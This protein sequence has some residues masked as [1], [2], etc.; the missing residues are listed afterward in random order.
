MPEPWPSV[1]T[2]THLEMLSPGELKPK[3]APAKQATIY[4]VPQPMPSLNRFFYYA[5][6]EEWGWFERRIWSPNDWSR[7]LNRPELETWIVSWSGVPAGY[8]ELERQPG[9]NVEISYFGLLPQYTQMKLGGWFLGEMIR[10][11]WT[12]GTNRVWVHTCDLDHPA[13]LANYKARGFREF[14]QTQEPGPIPL[15]EI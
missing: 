15:A 7:H 11:A 3:N 1:T 9:G 8:C 10:Q 4:R 6:G 14:K 12:G 13:A 5:I 2:V